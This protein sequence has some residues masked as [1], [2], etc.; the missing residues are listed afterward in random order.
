ML[1][2]QLNIIIKDSYVKGKHKDTGFD[3]F[4]DMKY[5]FAYLDVVECLSIFTQMFLG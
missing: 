4:F 3:Y 5:R 2:P 1:N